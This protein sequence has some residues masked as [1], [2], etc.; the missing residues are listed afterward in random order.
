MSEQSKPDYEEALK[1]YAYKAKLQYMQPNLQ[2]NNT[3]GRTRKIILFNPPFS[4]N[5]KTNVAKIL[6]QLID[7]HSPPANKLHKVFNCNTVKVGYSCAQNISQIIK[8]HNKKVT[9]IK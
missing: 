7:T 5:L 6:L 9:Q 3:R 1:K 4:L 2:E 8:G